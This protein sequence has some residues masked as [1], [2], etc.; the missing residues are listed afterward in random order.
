MRQKVW[1]LGSPILLP[2]G[3]YMGAWVIR[4]GQNCPNS[5]R[6]GGVRELGFWDGRLSRWPAIHSHTKALGHYVRIPVL[7][8]QR[9]CAARKILVIFGVW[10]EK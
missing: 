9:L 3:G 1:R 4:C 10:I 7:K 2:K 5:C 8:Y 6:A